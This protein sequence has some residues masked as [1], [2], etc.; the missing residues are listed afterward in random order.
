MRLLSSKYGT[1]VIQEANLKLESESYFEMH[2]F[3]AELFM[4]RQQHF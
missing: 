2:E 1:V 3:V 4:V